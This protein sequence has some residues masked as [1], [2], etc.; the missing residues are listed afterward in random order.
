M[1]YH[2]LARYIVCFGLS[3]LPVRVTTRIITFLIGNPYKPSFPLL[4]GGGTTQCMFELLVKKSSYIT[5]LSCDFF[6]LKKSWSIYFGK[7]TPCGIFPWH[8]TS[9]TASKKE[10]C[11]LP[12]PTGSISTWH[13]SASHSNRKLLDE[14]VALAEAEK[15]WGAEA[16]VCFLT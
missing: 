12:S 5:S 8:V 1:N 6:V 9:L 4:L 14:S 13:S 7:N 16:L 2:N 3:P 10:Q 15:K 11:A